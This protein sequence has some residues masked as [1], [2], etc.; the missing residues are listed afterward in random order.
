MR[1]SDKKLT[2]LDQ[3]LRAHIQKY[4]ERVKTDD[5]RFEALLEAT[6]A[7]VQAIA[8]LTEDTDEIVKI[9][10]DIKGAIRTSLMIQKFFLWVMKWGVI[11]TGIV[12]LFNWS[13]RI[14]VHLSNIFNRFIK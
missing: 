13:D 4:E 12:T 10:R 2:E 11:S 9:H 8:R 1:F 7:N 5:A 3:C 6:E 14:S